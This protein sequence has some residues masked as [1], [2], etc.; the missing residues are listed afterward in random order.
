MRMRPVRTRC[1]AKAIR[2]A[3]EA[4]ERR[5]LLSAGDL[6]PTFGT[7]GNELLPAGFGPVGYGVTATAVQADGKTLIAGSAGLSNS[8]SSSFFLER[9][10]IDGTPD[11]TF[12]QNG[13]VTTNLGGT[14]GASSIL[15]QPDGRIVLGGSRSN[16]VL[17][18]RADTQ[19]AI[20]RYN[21]NGSPDPS[22]GAGGIVLAQI[23]G[24]SSFFSLALMSD[25]RIVA[26]GT[27]IYRDPA[28]PGD[29]TYTVD[30]TEVARY[31]P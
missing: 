21:P 3:L 18:P 19:G 9:L 24:E 8:P 29:P 25:G 17:Y 1:S 27:G 16:G 28:R 4:L 15:I 26:A 30:A 12:G 14:A 20:V 31:T 13:I 10:N 5:T 23:P 2:T 6:D 7:G 11:R 22:F